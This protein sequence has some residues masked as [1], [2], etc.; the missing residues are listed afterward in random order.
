M[1]LIFNESISLRLKPAPNTSNIRILIEGCGS[2]ADKWKTI[3][4]RAE[5][6]ITLKGDGSITTTELDSKNGNIEVESFSDDVIANETI[7]AHNLAVNPAKGHVSVTAYD[8]IVLKKVVTAG[9][10]LT[11]PL[12]QQPV[13]S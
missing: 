6:E 10:N 5:A 3:G 13:R 12:K 2:A 8:D 4:A 11:L 7:T 1:P 9:G